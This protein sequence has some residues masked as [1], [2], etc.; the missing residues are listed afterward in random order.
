MAV[1]LYEESW[2]VL[3]KRHVASW[4]TAYNVEAFML[5]F[6]GQKV[7]SFDDFL[8]AFMK[9]P[10]KDEFVNA[11]YSKS[12]VFDVELAFELDLLSQDALVLLGAKELRESG[13]WK[14]K[15]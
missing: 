5:G 11:R 1:A 14:K 2:R 10:V 4:L 13:A 6:A 3:S 15:T 7:R 9:E 12:V 8:P